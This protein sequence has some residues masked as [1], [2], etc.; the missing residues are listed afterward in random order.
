MRKVTVTVPCSSANLGA[1]FDVLALALSLR[2]TVEFF[3]TRQGVEID[4]EG[5]GA[6]EIPTDTTNLVY[7]SAEAVFEKAGRRPSGLRIHAVNVVPPGSGMG[8]S[9][10]AIVGGVVAANAL[11]DARLPRE[12]LVRIAHEI[13]GHPDNVAAQILGSLTLVSAAGEELLVKRLDIPAMTVVVALPDFKL[14]TAEARRILPP[15]VALGD[16]IFN[17]GHAVFTIQAL[18]AGDYELLRFALNDRLHQ[19][20]RK[21]LIPGYDDVCAAARKVGAAALAISGAGPAVIAFAPRGHDVIANAMKT[22]FRTHGLGARTF[23]LPVDRQG[24]QVS[25]VQ[26]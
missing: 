24:V 23:I 15:Q 6:D 9:A 7:R 19:P 16:A 21:R 11:I 17:I 1:G 2:N 25:V 4:V 26:A 10:A 22:A 18:Q 13:E 8:S 3:E 20:Y 5:E 12:A 14:S